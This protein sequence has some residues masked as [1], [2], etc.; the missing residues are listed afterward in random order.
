MSFSLPNQL[1]FDL[2]EMLLTNP[3]MSI[4]NI[5]ELVMVE[6]YHKRILSETFAQKFLKNI[7]I[8]VHESFDSWLSMFKV[9]IKHALFFEKNGI[10]YTEILNLFNGGISTIHNIYSRIHSFCYNYKF[11]KTWSTILTFLEEH[12]QTI[13]KMVS[14]FE[15]IQAEFKSILEKCKEDELA[16]RVEDYP[17]SSNFLVE[18]PHKLSTCTIITFFKT[19]ICTAN[20]YKQIEMFS[21]FETTAEDFVFQY[22]MNTEFRSPTVFD[23]IK[24]FYFAIKSADALAD[25]SHE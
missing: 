17:I 25:D 4:K 15:V 8:T 10:H 23:I 21:K 13:Q 3:K 14:D 11:P 22:S 18:H 24:S 19:D 2:L 6:E 9:F 12:H 7:G 16:G 5:A 1:P 20:N